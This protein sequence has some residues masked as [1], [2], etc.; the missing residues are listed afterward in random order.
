MHFSHLKSWFM[1]MKFLNPFPKLI[2]YK[3]FNIKNSRIFN[4]FQNLSSRASKIA[5]IFTQWVNACSLA[6]LLSVVSDSG[7]HVTNAY[8]V[9]WI[10]LIKSPA[11]TPTTTPVKVTRSMTFS[12]IHFLNGRLSPLLPVSSKWYVRVGGIGVFASFAP[13]AMMIFPT[14][15]SSADDIFANK[16]PVSFVLFITISRTG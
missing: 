3:T 10:S 7:T 9:D 8:A 2:L 5:L 6:N 13:P 15:F 14:P 11:T 1:K 4:T 16:Y 12:L